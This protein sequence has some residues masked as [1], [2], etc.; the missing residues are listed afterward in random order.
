MDGPV[1][2]RAL[3][4]ALLVAAI[5]YQ[6]P[7]RLDHDVAWILSS[8][9]RLL[10]GAVLY[11]DVVDPNPPAIFF[12]NLPPAWISRVT[13]LS[14]TVVFKAYVI[15][16][17]LLS[18]GL[19]ARSLDHSLESA[20]PQLRAFVLVTLLALFLPGARAFFGQREHFMLLLVMPYVL[21]AAG[22]ARGRPGARPGSAAFTTLVG[23]LAGIGMAIKP[24]FLLLWLLIEIYLAIERG[25]WSLWKRRENWAI[26]LV[27]AILAAYIV[28]GAPD[29]Y[30]RVIPLA[31]RAFSIGDIPVMNLLFQPPVKLCAVALALVLCYVIPSRT[32]LR[33]LR[34]VVAIATVSLLASAIV[35]QK[36]FGYH[37]YPPGAATTL[38]FALMAAELT[39]WIPSMQRRFWWAFVLGTAGLAFLLVQ[40]RQVPRDDEVEQLIDVMKQHAPGE[41]V[42]LFNIGVY[43]AFPSVNYAGARWDSRFSSLWLLPAIYH[44]A[45]SPATG[46]PYHRP[47]EMGPAEKYFFDALVSDLVKTPPRLVM[48]D[49][50]TRSI[51]HGESNFELMEYLSQ[52]PRVGEIWRSYR[53]VM[54]IHCIEIYERQGGERKMVAE[55]DTIKPTL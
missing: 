52:D 5:A 18:L 53:H 13:H 24:Y 11:R 29:Y 51:G 27:Q 1:L 6:A 50:H 26:A 39:L 9:A 45:H 44:Q 2:W 46:F 34:H 40:K 43:P 10:D 17:I 8:A 35:Q 3:A 41:P 36:G 49:C 4:L 37:F 14:E 55:A 12:L 48:V 25:A 15:L 33:E 32:E 7:V 28:F 19:C 42:V 16:W 30:R 38:L 47:A 21:S 22:W 23:I 20:F 31:R 54:T